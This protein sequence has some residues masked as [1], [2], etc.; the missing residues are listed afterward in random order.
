MADFGELDEASLAALREYLADDLNSGIVQL[1]F[2]SLTFLEEGPSR[3]IPETVV[4]FEML[5]SA[6]YAS[7]DGWTHEDIKNGYPPESWRNDTI[8]VPRAFIGV[9]VDHWE[10]YKDPN[11]KRTLDEAMFMSGDGTAKEKLE[12]LS[13]TIQTSNLSFGI[14]LE[15]QRNNQK[16]SWNDSYKRIAAHFQ[17]KFPADE[18]TGYSE[19]TLKLTTKKIRDRLLVTFRQLGILK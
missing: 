2:R 14:R 1:Y 19:Q 5:M 16:S 3:K 13:K 10:R 4:A 15:T 12:L 6:Y 18:R 11:Y 8:E 7:M 9:L 17:E